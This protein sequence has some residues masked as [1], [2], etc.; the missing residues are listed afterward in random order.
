MSP[1]CQGSGIPISELLFQEQETSTHTQQC[2]FL[3]TSASS[4]SPYQSWEQQPFYFMLAQAMLFSIHCHPLNLPSA[5][6]Q[7]GEECGRAAS[8]DVLQTS[9][10]EYSLVQ[11]LAMHMLCMP[12]GLCWPRAFSS[13]HLPFTLSLHRDTQCQ[14]R[15]PVP[16][17][18]VL[19]RTE[20]IIPTYL[21]P[22]VGI[23]CLMNVPTCK[24]QWHRKPLAVFMQ[25]YI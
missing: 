8:S 1:K 17:K 13:Q 5:W 15:A 22:I 18:A 21:V 6:W 9:H 24:P 25:S 19:V 10:C 4:F 16:Y 23:T 2:M 14:G 3:A 20:I 11:A 12:H 7:Q